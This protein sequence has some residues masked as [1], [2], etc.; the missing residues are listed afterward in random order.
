MLKINILVVFVNLIIVAFQ[1]FVTLKKYFFLMPFIYSRYAIQC[2]NVG[3][4]DYLYH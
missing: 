3:Y 1:A 4:F 2:P